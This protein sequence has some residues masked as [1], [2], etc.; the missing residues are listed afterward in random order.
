[1]LK[2]T[3]FAALLVNYSIFLGYFTL[4]KGLCLF[5]ANHIDFSY[6]SLKK[7]VCVVLVLYNAFLSFIALEK[8]LSS[9]QLITLILALCH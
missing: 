4:D 7:K 8:A 9:L 3:L 2:T 1:M 6:T 5:T